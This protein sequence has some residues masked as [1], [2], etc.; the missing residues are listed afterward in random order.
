ML[1]LPSYIYIEHYTPLHQGQNYRLPRG[2]Q[3]DQARSV[4]IG[5][6]GAGVQPRG[7]GAAGPVHHLPQPLDAG[8]P[9]TAHEKQLWSHGSCNS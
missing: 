3:Q 9:C 8:L 1:R 2:S 4:D 5:Q 7:G 6:P